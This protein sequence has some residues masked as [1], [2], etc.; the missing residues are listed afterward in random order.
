[1]TDASIALKCKCGMLIW[2]LAL[3]ML[4]PVKMMA[5][6]IDLLNTR[7]KSPSLSP[8]LVFK[9]AVGEVQYHMSKIIFCVLKIRD[10]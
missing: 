7:L 8:G 5:A 6:L 4:H 1:M 3:V 9:F 2:I 10:H